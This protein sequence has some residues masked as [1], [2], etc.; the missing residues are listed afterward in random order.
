MAIQCSFL[1]EI[2]SLSALWLFLLVFLLSPIPSRQLEDDKFYSNDVIMLPNV[3]QQIFEAKSNVSITCASSF[4]GLAHQ[5]VSLTW[6]LPDYLSK[7]PEVY[8]VSSNTLTLLS[9]SGLFQLSKT[10]ERVQITWSRNDTHVSSTMIL[11]GAGPR[12]TGYYE[13]YLPS[14]PQMQAEQYIYIFSKFQMFNI[15]LQF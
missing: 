3:R 12:D 6:R 9:I 10:R 14:F 8:L 1:V 11:A 7:Y 13:C 2:P 4:L 15:M 5:N